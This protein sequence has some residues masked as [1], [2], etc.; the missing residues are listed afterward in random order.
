MT[1]K[2][3]YLT[4][5][6]M[7]GVAALM[8]LVFHRRWTLTHLGPLPFANAYLAVDFFFV[9][10][11][12]VI[13]LA[14]E[15]RLRAGMPLRE[16]LILRAIRLYPIVILGGVLAAIS[17]ALI[18]GG[19]KGLV[20]STLVTLGLPS[21]ASLSIEPFYPNGPIWSLFFEVLINMA[22]A[23]VLRVAPKALPALFGLS[24]IA[25]LIML[26]RHG[27]NVGFRFDTVYWGLARAAFPFGLGVVLYR[28]RDRLPALRI[29]FIPVCLILIAALALPPVVN[30]TLYGGLAVLIL[31][32]ALIVGGLASGPSAGLV[33]FAAWLGA[34]S[35]PVYGLHYPLYRMG[36]H[37][38]IRLG[39][40]RA[41][42]IPIFA[43]LAAV[44]ATVAFY[45]YDRPVRARL[46]RGFA[47]WRRGPAPRDRSEPASETEA[48]APV[49]GDR[50]R[51]VDGISG[52]QPQHIAGL[53]RQADAG[54]G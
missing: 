49:A 24:A 41:W 42:E 52:L 46:M 12:F 31:F 43:T 44:L 36:D 23:V 17:M 45:F 32:P 5:D 35:F 28:L 27:L 15:D 1:P 18:G 10:S 9:L 50:R 30:Q 34:I 25:W 16:F 4:L 14:Y 54:P 21:P 19:G 2:T 6:A 13:A 51:P 29:G 20:A 11:G 48:I 37:L 8:V 38:M 7:R 40:P 47:E 22:F 26:S 3:H 53:E 39:W 33:G